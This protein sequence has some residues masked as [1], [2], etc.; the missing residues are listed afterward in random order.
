M[1][2][3]LKIQELIFM[4]FMQKNPKPIF[5]N[6]NLKKQYFSHYILVECDWTKLLDVVGSPFKSLVVE[7][8]VLLIW[9]THNL[10]F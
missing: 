6:M 5:R 8:I 1:L 10:M 2:M 3:I 7:S 9:S 4:V